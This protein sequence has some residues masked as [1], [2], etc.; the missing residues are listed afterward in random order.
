MKY[1]NFKRP[2]FFTT[3]KN[4]NFKRY[5]FSNIYKYLNYRRYK[6]SPY[7]KILNIKKYKF[8]K[9]YN[10]INYKK[11]RIFLLYIAALTATSIIVYLSIPI[12]FSYD[13]INV[14]K[15]LCDDLKIKCQPVAINSGSVWP[16]KGNLNSNKKITIS[17][18]KEIDPNLDG[19][20]FIKILEENIYKE[21]YQM[22]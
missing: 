15:K 14:S 6:F 16:K 2:K 9:V 5:N 8:S 22:I 18:L 12:F 17:I 11:I 7:L 20:N 21:L 13:K 4:I 10:F 19:Q 1:I 3:I